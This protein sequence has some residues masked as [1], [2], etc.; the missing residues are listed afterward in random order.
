MMGVGQMGAFATELLAGVTSMIGHSL[1]TAPFLNG[2]RAQQGNVMITAVRL[3]RR[4]EREHRR[5][6]ERR[7]WEQ[8]RREG[9]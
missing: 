3:Q 2:A 4:R 7:A 9:E 8:A 5:L 1:I 6:H